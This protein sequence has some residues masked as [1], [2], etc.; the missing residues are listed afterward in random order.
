MMDLFTLKQQIT[1]AAELSALA[2]TR[3]LYP[4]MD[5][6]KYKEAVKIAGS[7]QWL[8]YHIERGNIVPIHR[9]TSK[10]SPIYYSRMDIAATKKAERELAR[11]I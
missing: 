8:K 2:I 1:E 5:E 4:A 7:E 6:V 3:Q 9:G 10:N 11:L